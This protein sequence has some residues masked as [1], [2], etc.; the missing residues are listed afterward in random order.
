MLKYGMALLAFIFSG[1]SS[2][3]KKVWYKAESNPPAMIEVNG[4]T[5]C[6]STPCE[7]WLKCVGFYSYTVRAQPIQNSLLN[8]YTD[9]KVV[10]PCQT[11]EK[12]LLLF[13]LHLAPVNAGQ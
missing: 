12:G 4:Q 11:N 6:R 10:N 1:C 2:A 5:V 9:T 8:Q 13:D 7:F 3:P